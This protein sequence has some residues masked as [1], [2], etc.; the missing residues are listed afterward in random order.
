MADGEGGKSGATDQTENRDLMLATA[1]TLAEYGIERITTQR[2]A[3]EWGKSQSLVHYYYPTKDDLITAFINYIRDR[4][5]Q[6]YQTRQEAAPEKRVEWILKRHFVGPHDPEDP[7][8]SRAILEIQRHAANS[9]QSHQA[10]E[11]LDN[12]A[13][14]FLHNA[15]RDGIE[16]GVFREVDVETT[17]TFLL[18]AVNG[19]IQRVSL[20]DD[21][22]I[23]RELEDGLDQYIESIL[24]IDSED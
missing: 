20:F 18:S 24:S 23:E 6:N 5:R 22:T 2:V 13:Q 3:D 21:G 9:E 8:F 17:V 12:E 1:R 15:L 4:T 16:E 7:G 14:E 11:Q 19:G 10:L